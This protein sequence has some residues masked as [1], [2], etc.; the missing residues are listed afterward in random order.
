LGRLLG[1]HLCRRVRFVGVFI[2]AHSFAHG[3]V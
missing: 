3:S 2:V 1:F